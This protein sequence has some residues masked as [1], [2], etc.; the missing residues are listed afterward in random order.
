MKKAM[1]CI[2]AVSLLAVL[3]GCEG[4]SAEGAVPTAVPQ[5]DTETVQ[6][7]GLTATELPVSDPA[8]YIG[9]DAAKAAALEHAGLGESEVTS[10]KVRLEDDDGRIVYDVEFYSGNAENN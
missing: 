9:E 6:A 5:T 10:V 2:L 3:A 4:G 7:S 8:A 1:I